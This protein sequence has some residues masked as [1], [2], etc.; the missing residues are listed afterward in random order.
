[1]NG[2]SHGNKLN[3]VIS[4]GRGKEK[5]CIKV[6][7][8]QRNHWLSIPSYFICLDALSCWKKKNALQNDFIMDLS[9]L[10]SA[11]KL[12]Y[13]T[14]FTANSIPCQWGSCCWTCSSCWVT[15]LLSSSL[16][17]PAR[18]WGLT[19]H[20]APQSCSDTSAPTSPAA[21]CAHRGFQGPSSP[22]DR[23]IM[24]EETTVNK[25]P[26]IPH[27]LPKLQQLLLLQFANRKPN[28]VRKEQQV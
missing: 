20:T 1:M 15:A 8:S 18:V 21:S 14:G 27:Q 2:K 4:T 6:F 23:Q 25:E 3:E 16:S 19:T 7:L 5:S 26:L 17:P 24:A 22:W 11:W 10:I 13:V 9:F 12:H 28:L